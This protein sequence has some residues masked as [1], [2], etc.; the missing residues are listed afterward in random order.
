[1]AVRIARAGRR[2][3]DPWPNGVD[4]WLR[5]GRFAAVM[6]DLEQID[7]RQPGRQQLRINGLF[8]VAHQ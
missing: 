5:G 6:G 7:V 1:M 2:H 8:D 3:G 4:E